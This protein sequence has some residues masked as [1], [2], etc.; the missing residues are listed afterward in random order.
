MPNYGGKSDAPE[1]YTDPSS[2]SKGY[3]TDQD[4]KIYPVE[5]KRK[6]REYMGGEGSMGFDRNQG[7][8][9]EGYVP[10]E[11]EGGTLGQNKL[12][13]IKSTSAGSSAI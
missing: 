5:N 7:A 10:P 13:R 12:Q 6:A 4:G 9:R 1:Q 2:A 3:R 11:A 8:T